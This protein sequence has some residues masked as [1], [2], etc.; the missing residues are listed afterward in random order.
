W[1]PPIFLAVIV[2]GFCTWEGGLIGIQEPHS[3]F[4]RFTDDLQAGKHVLFVDVSLPQEDILRRIV[5]DHPGL[6][7]AG[8]GPAAPGW[9]VSARTRIENMMKGTA[10][11]HQ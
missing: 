2:L 1:V 3:D 11:R 5:N 9:F 10:W 7:A 4:K 8:D 6:T